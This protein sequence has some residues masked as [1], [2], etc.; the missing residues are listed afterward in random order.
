MTCDPY[1]TRVA[2]LKKVLGAL[3]FLLLAGSPPHLAWASSAAPSPESGLRSECASL[4]S[5]ILNRPVNYCVVF[6]DDY[7][8]STGSRY[9]TLYFLHGLFENERSWLERGG[10][11]VLEE[12]LNQGQLGKFLVVLP[13]GG[14]TFYVNSLDGH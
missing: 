5:A 10:L 4:S 12:M 11:Q 8:S 9:P 2:R 7:A 13:D 14:R 1:P 3:V 6:P